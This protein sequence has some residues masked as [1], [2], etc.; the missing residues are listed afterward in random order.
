MLGARSLRNRDRTLLRCVA[1]AMFEGGPT[2]LTRQRLDRLVAHV[3]EML[4]AASPLVRT[5]L[6][7][8]MLVLLLSP[9]LLGM[10]VATLPG[11]SVEKR[12]RVLRALERSR[13]TSLLLMFVGVR[14]IMTMIF[15]E[16]A[17]E[18]AS[19]GYRATDQSR[20]V[21]HLA[22]LNAAP[23]PA[24]S[25]VRLREDRGAAADTDA[26]DPDASGEN[27]IAKDDVA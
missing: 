10:H 7:L 11:L 5:G 27:L 12:T 16:D 4:A 21:R 22:V 26:Y 24:E 18:L 13:F 2:P 14:A 17:A 3:D 23:A 1:E 25:G 6:R 9:M 15:Y 20:Y 19:M 8:A